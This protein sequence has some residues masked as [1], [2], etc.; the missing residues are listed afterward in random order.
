MYVKKKIIKG[1][2]AALLI[3]ALIGCG[4]KVSKEKEPYHI[5]IMTYN[6]TGNP[7][8]GEVGDEII[9]MVEKYTNTTLDIMWV[10][11]TN[12]PQKLSTVLTYTKDMPKIIVADGKS[13]SVLYAIQSGEVWD[14]TDLLEEYPNLSQ[15][16]PNINDNIRVNGRIYGVYRGRNIGRSGFSYREDW[17]DN[18]GLDEPKTLADLENMIRLFTF[19]D[20]DGNGIDDTYGLVLSKNESSLDIVMNW[21]GVPNGWGEAEDGQLLPA[22][23]FP[24]YKE[25][26]DWLQMMYEEGCINADFFIKDTLWM[27]AEMQNGVAGVLAE[28][29]DEGRRI[30]DY[31]TFHGMDGRIN[32]VGAIEGNDGVKR[33]LGNSGYSGFFMITKAAK[34]EEDVRACLDFL[35]KMNDEEMMMLADFGLEGRHYTWSDDNKLVRSKDSDLNLEFSAL[36]QL[37][38][39][40]AQLGVESVT[41]KETPLYDRQVKLY[42]EDLEFRVMNPTLPFM[43]DTVVYQEHGEILEQKL[44]DARIEYIMGTIDEEDLYKRWEDWNNSG[45]IDLINEIND[46]YR[47]RRQ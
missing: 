41:V 3:L 6:H 32:L 21:F 40:S 15:A 12:Y 26:L 42:Q 10:A 36:N 34:T 28:N 35:D 1:M 29:I 38:S 22:F 8:K 43:E 4:Q 45:G 17:A 16:N 5:S 47:L 30:Q 7:M 27:H 44:R 31:F 23:Y 18:L 19:N 39:Y 25:A 2:T 46:M 9:R 24:E 20:P 13:T 37:L 14:I 11:G 33:A